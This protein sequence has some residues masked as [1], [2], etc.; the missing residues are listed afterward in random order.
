MGSETKTLKAGKSSFGL[1]LNEVGH[2]LELYHMGKRT[3]KK[4][5]VALVSQNR[6]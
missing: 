2:S 4:R 1:D 5:Y 6:N 3:S